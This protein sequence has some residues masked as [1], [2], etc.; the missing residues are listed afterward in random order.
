[1]DLNY[2]KEILEYK[3]GNLYWKIRKSFN[4]TVGQIA[5][6][7]NQRGYWQVKIDGKMY[8][9]HHLIWWLVHGQKPQYIDHIDGIPSNNR[10]EN[11]RECTLSQNQKNAK[12]SSRNKTGIKNVFW[13]KNLRKYTI[14]IN[15]KVLG[16]TSNIKEAITFAVLMRAYLN[17]EF[18]RDK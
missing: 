18:A 14:K 12:L 13:N 11:L 10:I 6:R 1:M 17:G 7:P 5:G 3:D 2:L 8:L 15:G 16:H 9:V 4:I